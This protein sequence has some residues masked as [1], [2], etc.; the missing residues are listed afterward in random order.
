MEQSEPGLETWEDHLGDDLSE[1][2]VLMEL[3]NEWGLTCST[4]SYPGLFHS[5]PHSNSGPFSSNPHDDKQNSSEETILQ[6]KAF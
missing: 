1:S 5:W 3:A 4:L 6:S 2:K